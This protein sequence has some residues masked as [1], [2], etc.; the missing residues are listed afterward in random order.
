[1]YIQYI[2]FLNEAFEEEEPDFL[3][4]ARYL[5]QN[6]ILEEETKTRLEENLHWLET[7]IIQRKAVENVGQ[8]NC[9]TT[10]S[11]WWKGEAKTVLEKLEEIREIMESQEILVEK[12]EVSH[13]QNRLYEDKY[14]AWGSP[15]FL[16]VPASSV[17]DRVIH[18]KYE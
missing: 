12:M 15:D 17:Q 4:A 2:A 7:Q 9:V 13:L 11:V 14:Q 16:S 5:Y 3:T 18:E 6:A 1:M 8:E 10:H